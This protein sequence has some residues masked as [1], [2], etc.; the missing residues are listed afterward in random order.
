MGIGLVDPV[1]DL[2]ATNPASNPP[3]LEALGNDFRDGGFDQKKLIR[4]ITTS[5]VYGL[6]SLPNERNVVDTRNYSRYYR[7]AAPGGGPV[8]FGLPGDRRPRELRGDAPAARARSRS[9]PTA[10]T[11][12]S[13]TP[14]AGPTRTRIPLRTDRPTPRSSRPC[15]S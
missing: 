3:L 1:D 8:R 13:S 15:T 7:R 4:R 6:S 10:S 2:R 14:S 9:G 11:P 12:C 5:Y